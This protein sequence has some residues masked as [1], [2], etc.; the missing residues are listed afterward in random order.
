[1]IGQHETITIALTRLEYLEQAAKDL[2]QANKL[3][4]RLRAEN[5]VLKDDRARMWG[6]VDATRRHISIAGNAHKK[7]G[8]ALVAS[9]L[10]KAG[11]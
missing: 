4:A 7:Y 10:R 9:Q 11:L 5:T 8:V 1:M 2:E 6:V 3:I